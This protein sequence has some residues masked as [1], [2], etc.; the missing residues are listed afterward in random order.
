MDLLHI[1][2]VPALCLLYTCSMFDSYLFNMKNTILIVAFSPHRLITPS[3][4]FP[5]LCFV[6]IESGIRSYIS[7]GCPFNNGEANELFS[8]TILMTA[9]PLT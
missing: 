8:M 1:S 9:K 4:H 3:F 6:H 5:A 2:L 7:I